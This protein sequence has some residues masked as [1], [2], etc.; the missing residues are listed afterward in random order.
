MDEGK[1]AEGKEDLTKLQF[2][3]DEGAGICF[4]FIYKG[5]EGNE[6][7]FNT[8]RACM[9]ACS[10]KFDELYPAAGRLLQR[11][12]RESGCCMVAIFL[13]VDSKRT[14]KQE[15]YMTDTNCTVLH[16]C[17]GFYNNG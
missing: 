13:G 5:L 4:P 12:G 15:V 8:D 10:A 9:E 16:W 6:N 14:N 2:Y 7:R 17:I 3:Y 1:P 11:V